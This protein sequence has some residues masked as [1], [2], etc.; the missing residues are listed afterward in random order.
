M[1]FIGMEKKYNIEYLELD[2]DIYIEND[3]VKTR[4]NEN[5]IQEYCTW[6]ELWDRVRNAI[7]RIKEYEHN[8]S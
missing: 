4:L 5:N 7:I 6:E 2:K 1:I 8:N 3:K